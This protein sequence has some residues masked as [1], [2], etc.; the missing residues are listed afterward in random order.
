[1]SKMAELLQSFPEID[2]GPSPSRLSGV[3][4][5]KETKHIP[6]K[7]AVYGPGICIIVQ[8]HKIGYLGG[9][10]FQYDATHYLVTSV[11]MPLTAGT[12]GVLTK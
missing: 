11:T 2:D 3:L 8:G 1:M 7:P 6:R 5:F 10:K 9:Q 4:L 12:I